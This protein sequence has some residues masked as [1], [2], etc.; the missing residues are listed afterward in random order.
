ML[1]RKARIVSMTTL[2]PAFLLLIAADAPKEVNW[3]E[4]TVIGKLGKPLGTYLTIQGVPADRPLMMS[5]PL[6]V[7]T[8]DGVTL[9]KPI[10]VEVKTDIPFKGRNIVRLRGYEDGGMV[11]TPMDPEDKNADMPQAPYGFRVWFVGVKSVPTPLRQER[12]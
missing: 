3:N 1:A 9:G 10:L 5:N 12:H 8:I 7:D 2:I 6:V 11:S 4:I